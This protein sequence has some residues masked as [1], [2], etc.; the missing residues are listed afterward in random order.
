MVVPAEVTEA[1]FAHF[2]LDKDWPGMRLG[3]GGE[4]VET[5]ESMAGLYRTMII[6]VIAIYFLLVLLFNSFTQPLMVMI[7]IPFGVIGV[8]IAF[9]LHG[10]PF[11]FV[12][13]MG[14]VGLSGVVVNDSLVLVNHLNRLRKEGKYDNI[15]QL[16]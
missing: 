12:A 15:K 8:I 2:D 3:L 6:A 10:E 16:V 9:G 7:A 4:V 11:S 13:I 14:I 1:V 5:A